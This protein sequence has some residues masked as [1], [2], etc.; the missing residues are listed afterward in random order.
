MPEITK[1]VQ[2]IGEHD[3]QVEL[4]TLTIPKALNNG[5]VLVDEPSRDEGHISKHFDGDEH[6]QIINGG[7]FDADFLPVGLCKYNGTI[8]TDQPAPKLSGY[9]VFDENGTIDLLWKQRK[10]AQEAPSAL[11]S[12]PFIVDPGGKV[13]IHNRSGKSAA[14]T[15]LA[16]D[17]DDNLLIIITSHV[18]L[19]ELA[20]ILVK[21]LPQ[22]DRALNL[23]GGPSTGLL[24]DQTTIKNGAPVRNFIRLK[25]S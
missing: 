21:E 24:H 12:G 14:R 17:K 1:K 22:I 20:R 8:L 15:V 3:D 23:D 19:Y 13:G 9:V 6:E 10:Q 18:E 5:F 11:Q 4:I 16:I 25:R 2:V 7:Y